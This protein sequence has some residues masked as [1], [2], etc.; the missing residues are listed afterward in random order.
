MQGGN[1]TYQEMRRD[2]FYKYKKFIVPFAKKYE[3]ERRT[4]LLITSFVVFICLVLIFLLSFFALFSL[5]FCC[6]CCLLVFFVI[7]FRKFY[8][9][10]KKE[11]ENNIKLKI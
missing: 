3:K 9:S 11:Y 7:F 2:F 8:M 5:S 6:L 4:K 1:K 10:N